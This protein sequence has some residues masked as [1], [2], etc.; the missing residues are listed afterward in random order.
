MIKKGDVISNS[1][2]LYMVN[3]KYALREI[4][5]NRGKEYALKHN[6]RWLIVLMVIGCLQLT[7]CTQRPADTTT[8]ENSPVKVEHLSGADPTRITLTAQAAKR[9]DIQTVEVHQADVS[10]TQRKVAPYAAILYDTQGN[11]WVYTNPEQLVFVRQR[12]V[13]DHIDG[14]L[15]VLS[16]GPDSGTMVVTVGAEELFGSE[17]EFEEE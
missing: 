12:V 8:K 11:T 5:N 9:L 1:G 16:I 2:L 3:C 14:D 10:G 7:A 17:T 13:V 15:A 4:L 6:I